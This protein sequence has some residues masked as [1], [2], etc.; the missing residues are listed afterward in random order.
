MYRDR[1][2]EGFDAAAVVEVIEHLDPP[3]LAAFERVLF[4][5]A[6]P[7]TIV[8]TTP[9][10]EY[11]ALFENLPAGS[12]RH[13]DHRF[14]WTRP[15]FQTWA[16]AVAQRFGYDVRFLPVEPEDPNFGPPTQ[17]AIFKISGIISVLGFSCCGA[18]IAVFKPFP[19]IEKGL[20]SLLIL[21]YN[22]TKVVLRLNPV[23]LSEKW[24]VKMENIHITLKKNPFLDS[25]DFHPENPIHIETGPFPKFTE[26]RIDVHYH[27]ELGILLKGEVKR[28]CMDYTYEIGPGQ[29]WLC[30]YF[31][32]HSRITS[33]PPCDRVV[34]DILP[35][36]LLSF[37]FWPIANV[38]LMVPFRIA[39]RFRPQVATEDRKKM[40]NLGRQIQ[41][42]NSQ[43]NLKERNLWL[44]MLFVEVLLLA[45]RQWNPPL[46]LSE[47]HNPADFLKIKQAIA[48]VLDSGKRINES[49][50]ARACHL[51]LKTFH[52]LFRNL[53]GIT[54]SQFALHYRLFR[55][56]Q[57]LLI[58][59]EPV[60]IVAS[61]WGFT[62]TSHF[63]RCFKE[64]YGSTPQVFRH[65]HFKLGDKEE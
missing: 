30:S 23:C 46:S 8:L 48:M 28:Y 4:E 65:S 44:M 54:F 53:M 57:Q 34:I 15:E 29:I 47:Q 3:R 13:S 20:A 36:T 32:T 19:A 35:E 38:D 27:L 5:C 61:Q 60:K 16:K 59:D 9:N 37:N 56:A 39:P 50:V 52:I 12:L 41:W 14:E 17:M 25:Y 64:Y 26:N 18:E 58:S 63:D 51:N 10:R 6:R 62:D 24:K 42:L 45:M 7:A 31:E 49:A 1:R 40:I 33:K 22:D 11:N 2:L 43:D 55:T 21:L